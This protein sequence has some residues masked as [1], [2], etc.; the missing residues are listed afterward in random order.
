[1]FWGEYLSVGIRLVNEI[2]LTIKSYTNFGHVCVVIKNMAYQNMLW[3]SAS[4]DV[5]SSS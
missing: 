4:A 1:M 3:A 5:M 2:G